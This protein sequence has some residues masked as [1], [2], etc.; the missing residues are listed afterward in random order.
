MPF[1]VLEPTIWSLLE[2]PSFPLHHFHCAC[3][4]QKVEPRGANYFETTLGAAELHGGAVVEIPSSAG[5]ANQE[6]GAC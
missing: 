5:L 6:M 1:G 4:Q 2:L 3:C